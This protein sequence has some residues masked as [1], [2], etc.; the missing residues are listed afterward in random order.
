MKV[1][2]KERILGHMEIWNFSSHVKKI[3]ANKCSKYFQHKKKKFIYSGH[4]MFYLLHKHHNES[5]P[6]IFIGFY[7]QLSLKGHSQVIDMHITYQ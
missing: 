6:G 4:V 2:I 3:F 1:H 7:R 5:S